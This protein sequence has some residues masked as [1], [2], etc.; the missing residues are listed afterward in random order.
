[1][2]N[3]IGGEGDQSLQSYN[4]SSSSTSLPNNSIP[5]LRTIPNQQ[6]TSNHCHV[7]LTLIHPGYQS[8]ERHIHNRIIRKSQNNNN[9]FI[10][11]VDLAEENDI[12][13]LNEI[14]YQDN[15]IMD[16][17]SLRYSIKLN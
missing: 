16:E 11:D 8:S 10:Q 1:M 15:L 2:V 13:S 12:I 6:I 9:T 14:Q 4:T 3:G 17:S 5:S 7:S